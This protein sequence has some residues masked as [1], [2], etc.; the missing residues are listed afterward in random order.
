M[1]F[2]TQHERNAE[3]LQDLFHFL[4]ASPSAFQATQEMVQ[5]LQAA[6]FRPYDFNAQGPL[7]EGDKA[8]FCVNGSALYAFAIGRDW[9]S[10]SPRLLAAHSDSPGLKVKPQAL[11]RRENNYL[12]ATEVYGGPLLYT[13]FDRPLSLAGRAVFRGSK[14]FAPELCPVNLKRPLAILPSL[15]IHMQKGVNSNFAVEPQRVLLPVFAQNLPEGTDPLAQLLAEH[16]GR[17]VEELLDYEL[18]F[19]PCEAAAS[20][21]LDGEFYSSGR[22]DNLLSCHGGLRA[23]EACAEAESFRGICIFVAHDN[24][25]IGSRTRQGA[26]SSQLLRLWEA[27]MEGLGLD[28]AQG[29]QVLEKA[30]LL[31]AD[32]AHGV[33]P[34][35]TELSDATNRPQLNGGP[36]LKQAARFSYCSDAESSAIFRQLCQA[37]GV[38]CQTFVNRSDMP[39][40]STIGP[41]SSS[42][43]PVRCVDYGLPIWGMHSCRESGGSRDVYYQE[44]LLTLFFSYN[45]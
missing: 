31:S 35:Y 2:T 25:E 39:G 6:G 3:A 43:F 11:L 23:F 12:L 38:P 42:L 15:A 17:S 8:Y 22:L 44:R 30:I 36:V 7:K 16:C 27:I 20:L 29:Q 14:L 21:G 40:G 26:A 13:W 45:E 9:A 10:A 34:H 28:L 1:D 5:R 33:H 41:V 4:D 32:L 24:E 19:Y 18:Y 37:A